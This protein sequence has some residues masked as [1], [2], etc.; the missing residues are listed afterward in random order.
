MR[1][2]SC[3]KLVPDTYDGKQMHD[4]WCRP[5]HRDKP[6]RFQRYDETEKFRMDQAGAVI[7]KRLRQKNK[8]RVHG[9][10]VA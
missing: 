9:N 7:T 5:G 3:G 6:Y 4:K 1:C 8:K 10:D 2:P